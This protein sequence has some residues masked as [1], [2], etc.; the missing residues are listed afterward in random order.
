MTNFSKSGIFLI[1]AVFSLGDWVVPGFLMAAPHSRKVS[2][3]ESGS[4]FLGENNFDNSSSMLAGAGDVNGDGIDDFLVGAKNN[5]AAGENAGICYLIFGRKG[6]LPSKLA[7]KEA[8]VEIVGHEANNQ[9]GEAAAGVGD[10]NGDGIDDFLVSAPNA[11]GEGEG[12]GV[13]YLFFGRRNWKKK[14]SAIKADARYL[15][16]RD[17]DNAGLSVGYAG[18][19]NG[20]GYHD[21]L[22]GA[23]K[24]DNAGDNSGKVYL[25]L[26]KKEKWRSINKLTL[27]DASFI[28]EDKGDNAGISVASAGDVNGD[29][30][31]DFLVGASENSFENTNSGQT[32]LFL[33]RASGWERN[34]SLAQA[35]ASFVGE[36]A[37]DKSGFSVASA[38]DV[39]GD[40]LSDIVI[41]APRY[42]GSGPKSGAAYLF[43][44]K[45]TGWKLRT[46]V[47]EAAGVIWGEKKRNAFGVSVAGVGDVDNDGLDDFVVG[48]N[49]NREVKR[50][51]GKIYL[52]TGRRGNWP[53]NK[54]ASDE[55]A[56]MLLGEGRGDYAGVVVAYAGDINDD[57][58]DDF[59]VGADSNSEKGKS[60]GKG[61]LISY[62][63]NAL[64]KDLESLRLMTDNS[65]KRE[66]TGEIA[67]GKNLY[68]RMKA[69]DPDPEA[70]N[71]ALVTVNTG[72]ANKIRIKLRETALGSGVFQ[73]IAAVSSKGS[74]NL[75]N[76]IRVTSGET[77]AVIPRQ[78]PAKLVSVAQQ[79]SFESYSVDDNKEGKSSGNDNHRIEP[80]EKI[81]LTLSLR[82]HYFED[83]SQMAVKLESG[84]P[85]VKITEN[86][87]TYDSIKS[88]EVS[89]SKI[90]FLL[91]I[92]PEVPEG[93][94]IN[95]KIDMKTGEGNHWSDSFDLPVEKIV[96]I[97]GEVID[98]LTGKPLE[99]VLI[100]TDDQRKY[101][102]DVKGNYS[103][104]LSGKQEEITLSL[105][106]PGYLRKEFH[107]KS[108]SSKD[109]YLIAMNRRLSLG[110]ANTAYLGENTRDASGYSV[111]GLGDVNGDGYND[112]LI[113]AWSNDQGGIDA[114]KAYLFFGEEGKKRNYSLAFADAGFIGER[115][116][117]EAG[118]C[119]SAAGDVNKDGFADFLIGAPG[120]DQTG[121]KTGKT[122]LIFG[123]ATGWAKKQ[124][125]AK[126]GSSFTGE[127][128]H[129]HSGST[130]AGV[131]DVNGDGFDDFLIGAWSSDTG[132]VDGGQAYLVMGKKGPWTQSVSLSESNGSF[133][134][135]HERDEAARSV[136]YAGDVNGDGYD[137][138]LIGAPSCNEQKDFAG[139]SYLFFGR[140]EGFDWG[141]SLALADTSF[142]GVN[143]N[144]ASGMATSTA[145][146][147]NGDGYDDVIIGAWSNDLGG[148]DAGAAYLFFGKKEGWEKKV[149]LD[150]A[151][152]VFIGEHPYDAS[153]LKLSA[154]GD[155]NGDGFA[156]FLIGAWSRDSSGR[157]AGETYLILGKPGPWK[158]LIRLDLADLSFTGLKANDSSGRAL[159]YAGDVDGDGLDDILV[160]AWSNDQGAADAG[161]TYLVSYSHNLAPEKI[162]SIKLSDSSFR[163]EELRKVPPVFSPGEVEHIENVM[164]KETFLEL[165]PSK[166][167]R[168]F[169]MLEGQDRDPLKINV[170]KVM[171]SGSL[172]YSDQMVRL[173][174]T[175]P[176]SGYFVGSL[177]LSPDSSN[178]RN[179][180][181][182]TRGNHSMHVFAWSDGSKSARIV[183][184]DTFPPSLKAIKPK[185]KQ[186]QVSIN[187]DILLSVTDTAGIDADSLKLSVAGELVSPAL[188]RI[189]NGYRLYY[190]PSISFS[191]N[192]EVKVMV[193]AGDLSDMKNLLVAD[194]S[195]FVAAPGIL[196]N[197][198]FESDFDHWSAKNLKG[199]A[200]S[201]DTTVTHTGKKSCKIYF[202]GEADVKFLDLLQPGIP[203]R[204]NAEYLLSCYLKSENLTSN[205][206]IRIYL[207]GSDSMGRVAKKNSFFNYQSGQLLETN[208][209][210]RM[211]ISFKT[212]PDTEAVNVYIIRWDNG[213]KIAGTCWIDD[214]YLAEETEE[215]FSSSKFKGWF[216]NFLR[217]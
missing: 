149:L 140:A 46:P 49:K 94:S 204:P 60:A 93:K 153:A 77:I 3:S 10:V 160:G 128:L 63:K 78:K 136:S 48:A 89:R 23:P 148:I 216:S 173:I 53:K 213:E 68:I 110:E 135:E 40:R 139:K 217:E 187:S 91:E 16:E 207:E 107:I 33:G 11:D 130:L 109:D 117:D 71:I 111:A 157:N 86:T 26:G 69:T 56:F 84:N 165:D 196:E 155:V 79:V 99:N 168:L 200:V 184:K 52:F 83:V 87:I 183:I 124:S 58:A 1:L 170:V 125:L 122:Y 20:D 191:F 2:L 172:S 55:A 27:A 30:Y 59:L 24:N 195:F 14:L 18:D 103:I 82:N 113:G 198:G 61:Y 167:R 179:N 201:L 208:D 118:R 152:A 174:E 34:G 203:V 42:S 150:K 75:L 210:T 171:I 12:V 25:I 206:G 143:A 215:G 177:K 146:D 190:K 104:Y 22:I 45:R 114:G 133:V 158:P 97:K 131:G 180:R 186:K 176:A 66:M 199:A 37:G 43:L 9:F 120:N 21:F 175:S 151:G 80:G 44:G 161:A 134:G 162:K 211:I 70:T 178:T 188:T 102:S 105:T 5:D 57:G 39:N 47:E 214:F 32:Y 112:I 54:K 212:L 145:G 17:N 96:R 119:V 147:V 197:P 28:G 36:M 101:K 166:N 189:K 7:L 141:T 137:D 62:R 35:D 50:R 129:D 13:A 202:N 98:K 72:P 15:G 132:G 163:P 169:I 159:S 73:G 29:G 74:N 8:N 164:E 144:D 209:W 76:R 126:A 100:E 19:V 108:V 123:K 90:P 31:D 4:S 67:P 88:T 194:Y 106:R 85:K 65:F 6:G 181:I 154:A 51:A 92:G 185:E 116:Y 81:E 142:L 156:D 64:P 127:K 38:G 95:L 193:R 138:M 192:Q 121:D 182:K 115:P 41:G 205:S